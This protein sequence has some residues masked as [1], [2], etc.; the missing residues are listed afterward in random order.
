[1]TANGQLAVDPEDVV[2]L[3]RAT[4]TARHWP[5]TAWQAVRDEL[6]G[7]LIIDL[8]CQAQA[9]DVLTTLTS[10]GL[11]PARRPAACP[12]QNRAQVRVTGWD[13]R[14]LR[15]RLAVLLAGVD[16][17]S[18]EW[19]ATTEPTLYHYDHHAA[20][21]A[22]TGHEDPDLDCHVST[23]VET[24]LRR[25]NPLPHTTPAVNDIARLQQL[26]HAT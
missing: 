6:D 13:P 25:S 10:H 7:A 26:I 21:A 15:R 20:A 9:G 16:D 3:C 22:A 2:A 23:D 14:L 18:T 8:P 24:A 1:M 12:A 17:L 19:A 4:A 11:A 5:H